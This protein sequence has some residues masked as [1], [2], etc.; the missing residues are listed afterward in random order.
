MV[1]SPRS[2]EEFAWVKLV[3]TDL[4]G[5]TRAVQ[6]PGDAF[7]LALQEGVRVDGS[8]LE[9]R[10]RQ[11]ETDLVL[12]PDESTL[13][14]QSASS[15]RVICDLVDYEG[16]PW[17]LDP[18]HALRQMTQATPGVT[19]AWTG[20]AELEWYLL[21]PDLTPID[22]EGYFSYAR[23]D[24]ERLLEQT[25]VKLLAL[26]I[27]L[28]AAHHE[29]G[30]GQ[31]EVN[32][33]A[34]TPIALADALMD[35]RTIIA[36][37]A[38]AEGLIASFM[39]RPLNDLPGSGMHIHQLIPSATPTESI[40]VEQVI[41]GILDHSSALCAFGAPTINSYRRLHRGAEAPSHAIW[42][43]TSRSALIRLS[44]TGS[45]QASIEYRGSDSSAN[46]YL[47]LAALLAAGDCGIT[48]ELKL[49]APLEESVEGV[50]LAQV[51]TAP[52]QLPRS[53][54]QAIG[55]LLGDDQLIDS[56]DDRLIGRYS[57]DLMAEVEASQG[58]VSDWEQRR[59]LGSF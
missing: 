10:N 28:T 50:G 23:G 58:Y 27:T 25:A 44:Q 55:R 34:Q 43:H 5:A 12:R 6:I 29:A 8:A 56:F 49:P 4:G 37:M 51:E 35:A 40:R 19:R 24:G 9:G 48:N 53:L 2:S 32:L 38:H 11:I 15:A 17:P 22:A 39:A 30:P 21:R 7:D 47:V 3:F 13:R 45:G 18:R 36:D 41:A 1:L 42:A 59:Y 31:Y 46:P 16:A 52:A 33:A 26:G 54:E 14:P 20:A 57:E